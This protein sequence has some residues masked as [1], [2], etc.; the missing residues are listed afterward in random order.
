MARKI[1]L[2]AAS[3]PSHG[4]PSVSFRLRG[5]LYEAR[6]ALGGRKSV[7]WNLY[8]DGK[9]IGAAAHYFDDLVDYEEW[10]ATD[11]AGV[12]KLEAIV[13]EKID[14]EREAERVKRETPVKSLPGGVR[15]FADQGHRE[16]H[17]TS[18]GRKIVFRELFGASWTLEVDGGFRG[19]HGKIDER[20]DLL[21][22]EG[23]SLSE[24][25]AQQLYEEAVR[26]WRESGLQKRER[27]RKSAWEK[28]K[29]KEA[30]ATKH[31]RGENPRISSALGGRIRALVG[32]K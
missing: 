3:A 14:R 5:R 16:L 19:V 1:L 17:W 9:K 29:A 2:Q 12:R 8:R 11:S 24:N 10:D 27:M 22:P 28:S 26:L 15:V 7:A 18:R 25:D 31:E 32:K 21:P 13:R 20:S 30:R 6:A 23:T 4:A